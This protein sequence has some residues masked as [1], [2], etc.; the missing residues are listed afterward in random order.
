MTKKK[1]EVKIE[2]TEDFLEKITEAIF[3]LS[4]RDGQVYTKTDIYYTMIDMF[5]EKMKNNPDEIVIKKL[6]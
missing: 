3:L 5:F 2:H 6:K 4:E 1:I